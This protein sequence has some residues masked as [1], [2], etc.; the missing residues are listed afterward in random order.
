MAIIKLG[1][2]PGVFIEEKV[3]TALAITDQRLKVAGIVGVASPNIVVSDVAVTR[4][5]GATDTIPGFASADVLAILS[6]S[7][8]V[9][10]YG[11]N[12]SSYAAGIDFTVTGNT[13]TWLDEPVPIEG[14]VE[15]DTVLRGW[16][17]SGT[18]TIG[19]Y[20]LW[21]TAT[22]WGTGK[23]EIDTVTAAWGGTGTPDIGD[24]VIYNEDTH[25]Y[26]N[27]TEE[28]VGAVQIYDNVPETAGYVMA[29]EDIV[30]ALEVVEDT[31]VNSVAPAEGSTY[32]VTLNAKKTADYYLPKKW[33]KGQMQDIIN[34]YGAEYYTEDDTDVLNEVTL[35]AKLLFANGA[36]VIYT[37][38]AA[39]DAEGDLSLANLKT[40][41]DLYDDIDLQTLICLSVFTGEGAAENNRAL[42]DYL[43]QSVVDSSTPEE[44]FTRIC[45]ISALQ[46]VVASTAT[47][48]A[49]YREQRCVLVAPSMCTVLAENSVGDAKEFSVPTTFVAAAM[50]GITTNNSIPV[51]EPLTRKQP[52][53][54]YGVSTVYTKANIETLSAAGVFVIK[55]RGGVIS[56]N[57]SVTTDNTNQNNRELSVVLIKDQVMKD[58][59]YALDN[60]YIGHF[61]DRKK[62]PTTIKASIVTILNSFIGTLIQSFNDAD[63]VVVPDEVDSTRVNVTM[64]FAVLRPLNYI[65]ISYTVE[66]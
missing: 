62:T 1:K 53:G 22:A 10:A 23:V 40:A 35:G 8:Y 25:Q 38:Q 55:D 52:A 5:S 26:T 4:G 31:G 45:W 29:V 28:I 66:L 34:Y 59:Q 6:V 39:Y 16:V 32:Y 21:S 37:C 2:E 50:A 17:G 15:I 42:Q 12:I 46:D 49:L 57:Q 58:I 51:A 56:V 13:I 14:T 61:Y 43:V 33:G 7:S 9:N 41:I 11:T 64:G 20:V 30:G 54:I 65:Y 3:N 48:A 44:G 60:E 36:D 47:Q 24:F 19:D 27:S 63:I 18:P